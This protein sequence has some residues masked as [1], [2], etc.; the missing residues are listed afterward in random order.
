MPI[1]NIQILEGRP[2]EKSEKPDCPR[3]RYGVRRA[4]CPERKY[5]GARHGSSEDA[6]GYRRGSGIGETEVKR[7]HQLTWRS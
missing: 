4:G 5:P 7:I 3:D 2:P 6:L 1:I